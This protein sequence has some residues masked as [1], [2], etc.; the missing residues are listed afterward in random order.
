MRHSASMV[1]HML[2]EARFWENNTE[3][4]MCIFLLLFLTELGHIEFKQQNS[5]PEYVNTAANSPRPAGAYVSV[6]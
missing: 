2:Y 4:T 1:K 3:L 6:N 5:T